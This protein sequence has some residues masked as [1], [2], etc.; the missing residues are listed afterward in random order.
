M[1]IPYLKK[2]PETKKYH[3]IS[4]ID[5]YSF[6]D[7]KTPPIME[8]LKDSSKL[9]PEVKKYIDEE[10]AYTEHHLKDT[11]E[12]QTKL[13]NEIKGKIKL[14]DESVPFKD[15]KYY[16]WTKISKENQY[17]TKL[18]KKIG[19]SESEEYWNGQK[20]FEKHKSKFFSVGDLSVSYNDLL[21][22]Y[23]LDLKGSEYYTIYIRQISDQKIIEEEIKDT[24]GDIDWALDD[25]CFYYSKLDDK[26]RCKTIYRHRLGTSQKE[27]ELIF[28]EKLEQFTVSFGLTS[29]EKFHLIGSSDHDST[30]VYYFDAKDKNSKPK[31]FKKRE[32]K[33][34]YSVDSWKKF[35]YVHTNKDAEDF[36][37]CKVKHSNINEWKDYIPA[38]KGVLIGGLNFLD[39]YIIR[40][41]KSKALPKI[42]IRNYKTEKEEDITNIISNE[43]I[44]TPGASLMQKDTNTTKIHIGYDS[45]KT[46]GRTYEFD[47]VTK[48]KKLIKEVEIPSGHNPDDYI[49]KRLYA[50]SHDARQIPISLVHHKKTRLDGSAKLLL[51]G[52]S[53][54]GISIPPSFSSSKFCLVDR[55]II[56][57]I[58]HA[59]GSMDLGMHWWNEGKLKNKVNTFKD[60]IAT[61]NHLIEKKYT[62]KGKIIFLG[63]SA[64][65]LLG[66]AV[67]N[68][69]PDLFLS[70]VL[71][72]PF[73]NVLDTS[74]NENLP[75]S[76]NEYKEIGRPKKNKEDFDYIKS[77]SPYEN[78]SKKEYPSMFITTSLFD[79]RV[80][81]SE[82][83]KYTA[84]LREMKTDENL[85]L[86]KCE[87]AG[88]GGKTGR[89]N[90]ISELAETFAFILKSAD[91]KK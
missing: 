87:T 65:G 2:K 15:K 79:S 32:E 37:V 72:V 90:S 22:G 77:Y 5:N 38:K 91:I 47:I 88:H 7:Q 76:P 62:S 20:E 78:I 21:L 42:I 10:N 50:P 41:E 73:V 40:A 86:L 27:D 59:R 68:M 44:I 55:N 30:E 19:S 54:Y 56:Y 6:V 84:K 71:H 43:E 12:L 61:A 9:D 34:K 83:V 35:F 85:L 17:I 36:K 74:L 24:S 67:A 13:F 66:G 58:S 89:D 48:E 23:S 52:Y 18:R 63:G 60:Y 28:E 82:P 80:F 16:Y 14:D 81:Y 70:M 39:N 33:I 69:A 75:L 1:K 11:K 57:A 25:S 51:Y 8:V 3:N 64:G 45:L 29:D 53:C 49:V 31:L 4:W 46:Q 26:H